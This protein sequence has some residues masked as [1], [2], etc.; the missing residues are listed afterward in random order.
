MG[1]APGELPSKLGF[2]E[3][4]NEAARKLYRL[5]L[6]WYRGIDRPSLELI[7][8]RHI[9]PIVLYHQ[10]YGG[11]FTFRQWPVST[12][13][14]RLAWDKEM[15]E[16]WNAYAYHCNHIE[17]IEEEEYKTKRWEEG[18]T[19]MG[20]D[21][22][23][24]LSVPFVISPSLFEGKFG[25]LRNPDEAD[26]GDGS[27]GSGGNDGTAMFNAFV[28]APSDLA[29]PVLRNF[30][31]VDK[32]LTTMY[33][34]LV[35]LVPTFGQSI[36]QASRHKKLCLPHGTVGIDPAAF[37]RHA[38]GKAAAPFRCVY[39]NANQEYEYVLQQALAD[40]WIQ[41][42]H[43]PGESASQKKEWLRE[44][45]RDCNPKEEINGFSVWMKL[46]TEHPLPVVPDLEGLKQIFLL[47][48]PTSF[49]QI[50]GE[51]DDAVLVASTIPSIKS[52]GLVDENPL[53]S[54]D[55]PPSDVLSFL[56]EMA[57]S[58]K[59]REPSV[60]VY[61]DFGALGQSPEV[62]AQYLQAIVASYTMATTNSEKFS[63][64]ERT[65]ILSSPPDSPRWLHNQQVDL[66][67]SSPINPDALTSLDP[68]SK[69]ALVRETL[70]WLYET[71]LAHAAGWEVV[72]QG[73]YFAIHFNQSARLLEQREDAFRWASVEKN[74]LP[75]GVVEQTES[76]AKAEAWIATHVPLY[77][78]RL[79]AA[80]ASAKQVMAAYEKRHG[81]PLPKC[82][83]EMTMAPYEKLRSYQKAQ[84]DAAIVERDRCRAIVEKW[85]L[86]KE[87]SKFLVEGAERFSHGFYLVE[88]L[89]KQIHG[90]PGAKYMGSFFSGE[91][92]RYITMIWQKVDLT[93]SSTDKK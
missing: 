59:Y 86:P 63:E 70:D 78:G 39:F 72:K 80:E 46:H 31:Y 47:T 65:N 67:I 57:K 20:D 33:E 27:G 52:I 68:H 76:L 43:I 38:L 44:A 83:Q 55:V 7:E 32:T 21:E 29:A 74:V 1:F 4:V 71:R 18:L 48:S 77:A 91:K 60:A 81:K 34:A 85:K 93:S 54:E 82:R 69:I 87:F 14:E 30:L 61:P 49:L 58:Q 9:S 26:V 17:D 62:R 13:E 36:D 5:P 2:I 15:L 8:E 23:C 3:G 89:Y 25:D 90:L 50:L 28:D 66:V 22:P 10:C 41:Q 92:S 56:E 64:E 12:L 45:L 19:T 79:A 51:A 16:K 53:I 88:A 24:K 35:R 75:K 6:T 73:G 84:M 42:F 11:A 37:P 40:Y